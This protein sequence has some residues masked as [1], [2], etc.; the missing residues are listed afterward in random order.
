MDWF[1]TGY[2]E[3]NQE[4][5][6][7]IDTI[8]NKFGTNKCKLIFLL[9]PIK[10]NNDTTLRFHTFCKKHLT[11]RSIHFIDINHEIKPFEITS[12]LKDNIHTTNYGSTLYCNIIFNKFTELKNHITFPNKSTPTKF[13]HIKQMIVERTFNSHILLLGDCQIIGF[14]L[15]IGPHS[16]IIEIQNGT[17][18]KICN[19]WDRWCHYPR[20][21]FNLPMDLIG[22]SSLNISQKN[23]NTS[24]SKQEYVFEKISK[25][26]VIHNIYYIGNSLKIQNIIDGHKINRT[27][28]IL[29][30]IIGRL[31]QQ[32]NAIKQT[33]KSLDFIR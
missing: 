15:T 21:H 32:K 12:L 13:E 5:L 14:E 24:G 8:I 23:F 1:S 33:I 6:D 2:K 16:G 26:L 31:I 27:Q 11:K 22:S 10:N 7:C 9:F 30:K 4:T 25:S 28:L 17:N 29:R 18:V 19:T 3:T 20:R